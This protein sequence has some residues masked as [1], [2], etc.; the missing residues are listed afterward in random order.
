MPLEM[1]ERTTRGRA[2]G[3]DEIAIDAADGDL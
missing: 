3:G 2:R 1:R